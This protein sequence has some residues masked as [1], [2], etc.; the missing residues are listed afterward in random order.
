M[1]KI[2]MDGKYKDVSEKEYEQMFGKAPEQEKQPPTNEKR[3]EALEK[4]VADL[5][6]GVMSND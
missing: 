5:A 1:I 2:Y 4:A 6:L 3:L